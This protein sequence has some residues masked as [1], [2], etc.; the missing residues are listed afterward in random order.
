MTRSGSPRFA[1]IRAASD[2]AAYPPDAMSSFSAREY[3][4]IALSRSSS[5]SAVDICCE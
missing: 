5:L 3:A 1:A 2:S 4:A